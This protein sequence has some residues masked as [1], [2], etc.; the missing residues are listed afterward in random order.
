MKL[1]SAQTK[2]EWIAWVIFESVAFIY[3]KLFVFVEFNGVCIFKTIYIRFS[4]CLFR[5]V[6]IFAS[7]FIFLLRALRFFFARRRRRKAH[8]ETSK[9]TMADV[10]CVAKE[11]DSNFFINILFKVRFMEI[12]LFICVR[13]SCARLLF[14]SILRL[15]L[16]FWN[17]TKKLFCLCSN[18]FF[19]WI[20][21]YIFF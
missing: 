2:A 17:V 21:T 13:L 1:R 15:W 20:Y 19:I 4:Y 3:S 14:M 6:C 8:N 10:Y 5:C 7:L 11:A 18:R 16:P 12:S 9:W